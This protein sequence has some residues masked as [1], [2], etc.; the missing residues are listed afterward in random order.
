MGALLRVTG[1]AK[2]GYFCKPHYCSFHE[3]SIS[4]HKICPH[5]DIQVNKNPSHATSEPI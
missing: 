4:D 1:T 2:F 3:D 5:L